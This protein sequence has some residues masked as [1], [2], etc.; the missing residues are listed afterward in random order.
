[1]KIVLTR[2]YQDNETLGDA[3]VLDDNGNEVYKFNVL[4][5]PYLD[6][7]P[8][9]S[10]IPV[11]TYPV[12]KSAGWGNIPYP[13]FA[14]LNV[15]N[16]QGICIHIGNYAEGVRV[17]SEGCLLVADGFAD[18]NGDGH[19]DGIDSGKTLNKLLDLLPDSFTIEIL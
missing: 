4:E 1:M 10:C 3:V 2:T 13:H 8:Q 9:T 15:P 11:G 14:L 5:L 17:D 7:H 6:N 18:I 12:I 19:L 16:R